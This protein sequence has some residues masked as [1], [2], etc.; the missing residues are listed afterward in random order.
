M[1]PMALVFPIP[2][3]IYRARRQTI[4]DEGPAFWITW[5]MAMRVGSRMDG[6]LSVTYSPGLTRL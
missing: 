1:E 5:D 2:L 4:A 3:Y 6:G